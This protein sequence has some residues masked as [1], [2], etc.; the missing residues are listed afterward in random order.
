MIPATAVQ[1]HAT[2]DDLLSAALTSAIISAALEVHS[3]LGPGLLEGPY[4]ECLCHELHLRN[5]SFRRQVP[6][7]V[8]YKGVHLDCGYR[9]DLLVNDEVVVELKALERILRV[10][11]AELMTTSD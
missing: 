10:H 3:A 2:R 8:I 11:E 7:P 5:I 9:L 4:E 1:N 6:L